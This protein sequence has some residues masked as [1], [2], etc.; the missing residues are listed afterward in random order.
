MLARPTSTAQT[1]V[2]R[3]LRVQQ[4]NKDFN[5]QLV[6]VCGAYATYLVAGSAGTCRTDGGATFS[7]KFVASD[8]STR[9]YFHP[10]LLGQTKLAKVSWGAGYWG[11]P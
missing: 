10:S 2:D 6:A 3:R 1:D 9:D 4:R 7:T 8:V 5:A 11:G